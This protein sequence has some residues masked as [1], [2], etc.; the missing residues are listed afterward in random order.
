MAAL[1]NRKRVQHRAFLYSWQSE[2][3]AMLH[4]SFQLLLDSLQPLFH[5]GECLSKI[6]QHAD[7]RSAAFALNGAD[8]CPGVS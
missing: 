8:I 2:I 4:L 3:R 5:I 7:Y 6:I 1:S